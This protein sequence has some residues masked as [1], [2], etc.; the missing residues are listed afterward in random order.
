MKSELR[1]GDKLIRQLRRLES[2][3]QKK[4]VRKALRAG[5]KPI[6]KIAKA[7]APVKSGRMKKGIRVRVGRSRKGVISVL[8]SLAKKWFTGPTF[9]GGFVVFGHK[10]GKRQSRGK[11]AKASDTRAS[12]P[13][14]TFLQDAMASGESAAI[15]SITA[16]LKAQIEQDV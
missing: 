8:V 11:G 6:A 13:G 12:V 2:N 16:S 10:I 9:Y 3:V 1:G 7:T 4:Y 15:S 14:N 5:A